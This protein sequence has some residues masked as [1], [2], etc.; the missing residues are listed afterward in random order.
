MGIIILPFI[1]GAFVLG[2]IAIVKS[3]NLLK[4]KIIGLNE[5]I[6]GLFLSLLLYGLTV[7][8]Y[9]LEDRTWA[10]SVAFRLPMIMVYI[11]FVIYLVS[12]NNSNY[13]TVNLSNIFLIS[14]GFTIIFSLVFNTTFFGIIDYLGIEK[15]H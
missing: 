3:I 14:I 12:K 8:T 5:L 11:P 15:Y 4:S 10:L 2:I 13:K 6:L 9:V 7:L 1:F